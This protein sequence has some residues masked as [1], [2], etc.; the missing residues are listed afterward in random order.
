MAYRRA[1]GDTNSPPQVLQGGLDLSGATL[2][3]SLR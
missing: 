2:F 3:Q 1:S